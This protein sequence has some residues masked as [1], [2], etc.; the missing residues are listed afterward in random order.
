MESVG[1]NPIGVAIQRFMNTNKYDVIIVGA[2]LAGLSAGKTLHNLGYKILIIEKENSI[3]GKLKSKSHLGFNID[4]GFQ[5]LL[6]GY[7]ETS[8]ILDYKKLSLNYFDNGAL[9]WDGKKFN[10]ISDPTRNIKTIIES[11]KSPVGTLQDKLRILILKY[12]LYWKNNNDILNQD[13]YETITYFIKKKFSTKFINNFL[14]PFFSGILLDKSLQSPHTFTQYLFKTFSKSTTAIPSNGI[15]AIPDELA[16]GI[17]KDQIINNT[18]VKKIYKNSIM[19]KNGEE[20]FCKQVICAT[21]NINAQLVSSLKNIKSIN[22]YGCITHYFTIDNLKNG[23]GKQADTKKIILNGSNKGYINNVAIMSNIAKTYAPANK[24]LLAVTSLDINSRYNQIR[25]EL[26]QWFNIENSQ[27]SHIESV[28]IKNALP[29][30]KKIDDKNIEIDKNG[31]IY[32]GDYLSHPSI[33]G[34]ISSGI[35]AGDKANEVILNYRQ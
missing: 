35:Y 8:N 22:Y 7:E 2:G 24:N 15:Q 4:Y 25:N 29:K 3:G 18:E 1:S 28:K 16:R 17:P 33:E 13:D 14:K 26:A 34:A 10:S 5:V 19:L 9:I 20:F 32:C 27:I 23:L 11:F 31:I 6:T 12:E 30:L 21:D